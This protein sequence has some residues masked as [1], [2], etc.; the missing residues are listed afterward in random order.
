MTR[1]LVVEDNPTIQRMLV[2]VVEAQGYEAVRARDGTEAVRHLS[3]QRFD[4]VISDIK[5]PK[6]DGLALLEH[7]RTSAT[8]AT[9]PVLL[10]TARLDAYDDDVAGDDRRT[11]FM[12]KPLA[13]G[14]LVEAVARMLSDDKE[15]NSV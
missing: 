12:T 1:I 15:G 4:M 11:T 7:I 14:Q 2:Y 8:T 6:M 13:S 3:Q 9:V 10:L 5:M